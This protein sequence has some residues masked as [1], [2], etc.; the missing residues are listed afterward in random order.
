MSKVIA[1]IKL[2]ETEIVRSVRKTWGF[3]PATKVFKSKKAYSRRANKAAA[4][5]WD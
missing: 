3:M 5:D 1:T 4:K 2:S